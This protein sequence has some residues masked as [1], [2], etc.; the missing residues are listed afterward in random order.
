MKNQ[1]IE[2]LIHQFKSIFNTTD[3]RVSAL[4]QSGSNRKY[5]RIQNENQ[6]A[7]GTINPDIRENEAF[8]YLS[9]HFNKYSIPVPKIFYYHKPDGIYLQEDLGDTRL[10]Q[11][12][13]NKLT[14]GSI[15]LYKSALRQLI[16]IQQTALTDLD[17]SVCYPRSSFDYQ[18]MQWDLNYFKYMFLKLADISYDEQLLEND[19][20]KLIQWLSGATDSFFMYR[21]F[22]SQNIMIYQKTPYFID[23]QGGRKGP[24]QYDLASLLF[25]AKAGLPS[26]TRQQL[27][28]F[29]THELEKNGLISKKDFL[30][31]YYG[32]VLLRILQAFGAY[33][34]RGFFEGKQLFLQSI[35]PGLQNIEWLLNNNHIP[36]QFTHL[37]DCLKQMTESPKL[38]Q[39]KPYAPKGL[40]ISVNSFSYRKGYPYDNTGNGGGHVFDCRVLPNP[41]RLEQYKMSTG[42]D[43]DV[44]A[45]LQ[46]ENIV[47]DF[48]NDACS[49]VMRSVEEYQKNG[50]K[51]LQVNFGCTGGQH[52]SVYCAEETARRIKQTYHIPVTI[53]HREQEQYGQNTL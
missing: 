1:Q 43:P 10:Y 51:H 53:T 13:G 6:S 4:P 41:G 23:Y 7:I 14:D 42:K 33:G 8:I 45:F 26:E 17:F 2:A 18:S 28:D 12:T 38:Q 15:E 35:A 37:I 49:I 22:K 11:F 3:V 29:Y 36:D 52:R 50:Y 5:Y 34:Y 25:E 32:F 46:K 20:N 31:T 30:Y 9:R 40:T 48:I 19:F 21:D 47:D 44:I 16:H 27:L 39:L 24:L